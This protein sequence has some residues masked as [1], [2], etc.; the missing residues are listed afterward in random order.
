MR[1]RADTPLAPRGQIPTI[2]YIALITRAAMLSHLREDSKP[3]N[4]RVQLPTGARF[5]SLL[6]DDQWCSQ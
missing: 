5:R 1:R 4:L 2:W 3:A 6:Q